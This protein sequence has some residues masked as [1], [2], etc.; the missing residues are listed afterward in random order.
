[1]RSNKHESVFELEFDLDEV[2]QNTDRRR[3]MV[4]ITSTVRLFVAG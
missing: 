2:R 3:K 4:P 1:M